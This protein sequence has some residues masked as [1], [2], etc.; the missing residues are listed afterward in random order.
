MVVSILK[1]TS[2]RILFVQSAKNLNE[3]YFPQGGIEEGESP[4]SAILREIQEEIGISFD[5]LSE[6]EFRGCEVLDAESSR[7]DKRGFTKGKRYFFFSALY[8]GPTVLVIDVKELNNYR[9]VAP[10]DILDILATTRN[11]KKLLMLKFLAD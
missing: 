10:A 2:G 9:W 11:D 1:D 7:L 6:P 3:W 5:Q 8:D 4:K